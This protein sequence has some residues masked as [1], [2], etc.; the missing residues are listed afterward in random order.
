[1]RFMYIERER[2]REC[3]RRA[4]R[5]LFAK[6]RRRSRSKVVRV[7]AKSQH[8]RVK[9]QSKTA[10]QTIV[11]EWVQLFVNFLSVFCRG[12]VHRA[13]NKSFSPHPPSRPPTHVTILRVV[14][15]LLPPIPKPSPKSSKSSSHLPSCPSALPHHP[16]SC[17]QTHAPSPSRVVAPPLAPRALLIS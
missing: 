16:L 13:V 5:T 4:L 7:T 6:Y 8:A 10:A 9:S 2:E 14:S 17:R 3:T 12:W 15:W 11:I 1:M